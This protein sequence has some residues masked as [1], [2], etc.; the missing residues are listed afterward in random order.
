MN[1]V[2]VAHC[3]DEITEDLKLFVEF[4]NV[5]DHVMYRKVADNIYYMAQWLLEE[6]EK[7]E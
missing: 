2:N 1:D 3:I 4:W 5:G 6:V 7:R